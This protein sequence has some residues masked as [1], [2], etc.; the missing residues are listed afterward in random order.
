MFHKVSITLRY[1]YKYF[2]VLI[3]GL[4]ATCSK[5]RLHLDAI[6]FPSIDKRF[7]CA[8]TIIILY[9]IIIEC[10]L[11]LFLNLISIYHIY[12]EI[13]TSMKCLL[14]TSTM[15]TKCS[16]AFTNNLQQNFIYI[17][18]SLKMFFL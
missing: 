11:N 17:I 14:F 16:I 10:V 4:I 3:L 9:I 2:A 8:V 18:Q 5:F 1:C 12:S 15:S 6:M 7:E 13:I